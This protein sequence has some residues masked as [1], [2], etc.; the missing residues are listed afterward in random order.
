M[1]DVR[2]RVRIEVRRRQKSR[3]V[4]VLDGRKVGR[5]KVDNDGAGGETKYG[6]Q[7]NVRRL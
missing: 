6:L 2:S 1:E 5:S 4:M 3:E 7:K